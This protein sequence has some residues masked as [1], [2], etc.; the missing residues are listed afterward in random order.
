MRIGK[1]QKAILRVLCERRHNNDEFGW[2]SKKEL[3]H[4]ALGPD[5]VADGRS[6]IDGLKQKGLVHTYRLTDKTLCVGLSVESWE[7]VDPMFPEISGIEPGTHLRVTQDDHNPYVSLS[8]IVAFLE[9]EVQDGDWLIRFGVDPTSA[10]SYRGYYYELAFEP[11]R[12]VPA[13]KMLASFK[14]SLGKTFEGWKGG[15][16]KMHEDTYV[17]ITFSGNSGGDMIGRTLLH[18]WKADR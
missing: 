14:D 9:H 17:Y 18:Y 12:N 8:G 2:P 16:Y 13:S 6:A 4:A 10:H 15:D 1:N 7:I 5:L 11:M 3:I